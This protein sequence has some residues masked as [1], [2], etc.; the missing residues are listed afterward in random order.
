[1][2]ILVFNVLRAVWGL[3]HD[4]QFG[5][6]AFLTLLS[7]AT[8]TVFY[9]VVAALRI[10]DALYFSVITLT[11]VGYGD[12]APETDAGKL[13]TSAYVLLGIGILA[14][15]VTRLAAEMA[16]TPAL[17]HRRSH[18]PAGDGAPSADPRPEAC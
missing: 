15:F 1:M 8:G 14:A 10:V 4:S 18:Q 11:T 17:P 5:A 12:F 6:L 16:R 13:F 7:I 3:R 2:P 9:S